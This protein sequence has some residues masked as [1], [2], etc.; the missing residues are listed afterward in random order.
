ME[1]QPKR[2]LA[3]LR[4]PNLTSIWSRVHSCSMCSTCI[5]QNKT[6]YFM[7]VYW[8]ETCISF[9]CGY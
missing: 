9:T 6:T 3:S 4:Q 7:P 5:L 8:C 2:F 1:M